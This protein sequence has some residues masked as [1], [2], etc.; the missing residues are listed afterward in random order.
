MNPKNVSS[1]DSS[2]EEEI[3]RD[4]DKEAQLKKSANK[5]GYKPKKSLTLNWDQIMNFMN[6]APDDAYLGTKITPGVNTLNYT[7]KYEA[8]PWDSDDFLSGA[9][10][11]T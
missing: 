5:I 8:D 6:N 10:R 11:R 9:T 1:D 3:L 4:F 7:I 2:D